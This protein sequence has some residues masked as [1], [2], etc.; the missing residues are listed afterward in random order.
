MRHGRLYLYAVSDVDKGWSPFTVGT[1]ADLKEAGITPA[2]GMRLRFYND[3][4]DDL[5]NP[6][7]LIFDGTA[8]FVP[9]RGWGAC[10]DVSTFHWESDERKARELRGKS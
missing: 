6:D 2:E 9:G 8:H 10:I 5:G 1:Y 4:A 7:D 3:D